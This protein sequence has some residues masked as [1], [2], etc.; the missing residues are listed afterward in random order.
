MTTATTAPAGADANCRH[1]YGYGDPNHNDSILQTITKCVCACVSV[2]CCLKD[3][4]VP[5]LD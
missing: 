1:L 2:G 4:P 5:A 3:R